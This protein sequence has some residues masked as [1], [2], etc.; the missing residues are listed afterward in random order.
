MFPGVAHPREAHPGAPDRR[1]ILTEA[2][3]RMFPPPVDAGPPPNRERSPR[4]GT[5]VAG[6]TPSRTPLR[7][8]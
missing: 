2:H 6:N 8:R 1:E 4:P 3:C 7:G 5:T